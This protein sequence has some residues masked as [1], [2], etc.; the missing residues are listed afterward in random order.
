MRMFRLKLVVMASLLVAFIGTGVARAQFSLAPAGSGH[1]IYSG[2][3]YRYGPSFIR[4]ADG[5][6]DMWTCSPG[7]GSQWDYIRY[8][9]ST[10]DG[11]TF[12]NEQ[13]VLQPT[14]TTGSADFYSTCDPGVVKFGG[15]YY[16]AYTS[17]NQ[18]NGSYNNVFVA[19]STN[20]TGPFDKWNGTGWGGSPQPFI[21][22]GGT[23]GAYGD[24]EPALVVKDTTL[25]IY[26]SEYTTTSNTTQVATAS[27]TNANWPGS[28][29]LRGTAITRQGILYTD[30]NIQDSTDHKY[31][32]SL[33]MFIAVDTAFRF[34]SN[35]YVQVYESSDGLTYT[36][37]SQLTQNLTA[38]G[39]NMGISGDALGQFDPLVHD[40]IAYAHGTTWGVWNTYLQP[41]TLSNLST[42]A[43]TDRNNSPGSFT[44][45]NDIKNAIMRVQPFKVTGTTLSRLDMWLYKNGSPAGNLVIRVFALDGSYNPTGLPL[46]TAN[47]P[48]GAVSATPGWVTIYPNVSN[49]TPGGT[50][51]YLL[52]SPGTT[53]A[54]TTNSYGWVYNDSNLYPP[55]YERYTTNSGTNWT[56]ET[57]RSMKF[58]SY[59]SA[60]SDQNN[61]SGAF[62]NWNDVYASTQRLQTFTPSSTTLP[63]VDIWTEKSGTPA[64]DLVV[65]V[66]AVDG[67]NN[68]TGA[69]LYTKSINPALVSTSFGWLRI[70]PNLT[71]L[72]SGGHYAFVLSSPSTTGV[73][74]AYGWAYND[75]NLY[76][77]G[78][79]RY[80]TDGGSLWTSET[81]RS[82]KFI[83]YK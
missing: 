73:A 37:S 74:N 25:Y 53:D 59:A 51:G 32:P 67:S 68:P 78:V 11:A 80:S 29:T 30:P 44:N 70:Y 72:T 31:I 14:T 38:Y 20:A 4:N 33:N 40:F 49:L 24:G 65:K 66:F 17:T 64:G 62:S 10:D 69:A 3:N 2:G 27:T 28:V 50:Y 34:S 9:K 6:I 36:P 81:S 45:W 83:T 76:G 61:S 54:G 43:Q 39:H 57:N 41:F 8:S 82:L 56:T 52:S 58:I 63:E 19:R 12:G 22:Y 55:Y 13:I 77:S 48:P 79:E 16:L 21:T 15:Y 42:A 18:S 7:S 47:I 23:D 1:D 60:V 26:Y 5:S 46:Y 35:F 75:S 71:G